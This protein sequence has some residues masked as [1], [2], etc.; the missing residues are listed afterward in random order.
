MSVKIS[1]HVS[2]EATTVG[3]WF[4]Y[5]FLTSLIV[6]NVREIAGMVYSVV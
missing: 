3:K 5:G 2:V 4:V 6:F 1:D